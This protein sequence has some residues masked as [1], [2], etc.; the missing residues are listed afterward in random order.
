VSTTVAR[1]QAVLSA[2]TSDFD[3]AMGRSESRM[4][5]VAKTAGKAGL[6]GAIIGL[7][8]AAKVGFSEFMEAEKVTAQT[9]AVL[10]STGGVANVTAKEVDKLSTSLMRKSGVDDEQVKTG[11]NMLLTFTKIRNETGQG[12]KVFDEATKA[13]LNLSVAMGKDMQSSALLVGKA[14]ND[15]IKGM[16]ALTRAGVQFTEEQKETVKALIASGDQ[17]GA[18]KVILKELETQFGG[19]AEAAGKTFGGQINILKES[20]T[21][22][23]GEGIG[24]L[25]PKLAEFATWITETALPKLKDFV[26][27]LTGNESVKGALKGVKEFLDESFFPAIKGIAGVFTT[28]L[29]TVKKVL[30]EKKPELETIFGGIKK[31][32]EGIYVVFN[33]VIIPALK[34]IF[35]E[36]GPFDIAFGLAITIIAGV[37]KVI[38][39]IVT[40]T[41]DTFN[42]VAKF[43]DKTAIPAFEKAWGLIK[44]PI[45][46][47]LEAVRAI[48]DTIKDVVKWIGKIKVPGVGSGPAIEEIFPGKGDAHDPR[49]GIGYD[50]MGASPVM[51]PFAAGAAGYGLRV[52]SG[53]RPGAITANG[54]P[55]DHGIGKAL[56]VAGSAAAMAGFFKSLIGNR[57]VKQAFYDPLGSIFAGL[58]NSY[59]EGGHSDHVHVA[60]Y[61]KGG[62][63][64]EG[65]SIA[66]NF[67][68]RP[69][70]V[71][72]GGLTVNFNGP[73]WDQRTITEV[74]RDAIYQGR[75]LGWAV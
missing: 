68:G 48:L 55:S 56:D 9:N 5:S 27:G 47:V 25:M 29:G 32:S 57:S 10:K 30:D 3:K 50:L 15:P 12:N 26:K 69:E 54:T 35:K 19:S 59:R 62:Y 24:K 46:A 75:N 66:G 13:T 61:D 53:L 36:G 7:G 52:T 70:R 18:Q 38:S 23:L 17:M 8:Y 14:L 41:R 45:D 39:G 60:T 42:A 51:A 34:F 49:K 71:G 44:A 40:T 74:V 22:L 11:A 64:P 37:V 20:M 65:W 16:S 58:W 72:G 43:M 1:L 2:D 31:A 6:A 73:V 21:N 4:S 33:E 67:T 28:A 63:L